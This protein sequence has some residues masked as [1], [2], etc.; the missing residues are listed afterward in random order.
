MINSLEK[1]I[2]KLEKVVD[3]NIFDQNYI[4]LVAHYVNIG[5]SYIV[6]DTNKALE[7]LQKAY[8]MNTDFFNYYSK[9]R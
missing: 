8:Q 4:N 5:K 3:F 9:Y 6:V 1:E 2:K 7:F